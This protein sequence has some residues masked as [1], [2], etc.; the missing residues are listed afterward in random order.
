MKCR[1]ACLLTAVLLQLHSIAQLQPIQKTDTVFAFF[2]YQL[3]KEVGMEDAFNTGYQRDLEWHKSQHDQW[4]WVG[5]YVSNGSRRGRF[6]DATPNHSWKDFDNWNVSGAENS[7]LNKV[8]WL[9]YVE[10]QDGSYRLVLT[11]YSLTHKD[12]FKTANLQVFHLSIDISREKDFIA[13][14]EKRYH[15]LKT[16]FAT[17]GF[18]WMKTVSG[19]SMQDYFLFVPMS[20]L[21]QFKQVSNIFS[22]ETMDAATYEFYTK[23]VKNN[24]SELWSYKPALSL[25]PSNQ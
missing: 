3:K 23:S 18:A 16:N 21:E 15:Y 24:Y 1:I 14:M 20:R 19:G 11:D 12:W 10:N 25:Y 8:H 6:I 5:W 7:K 17:N 9:P 13:F 22:A 2:E 4:T